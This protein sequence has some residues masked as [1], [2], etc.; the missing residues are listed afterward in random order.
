[1]ARHRAF[2]YE[3]ADPVLYE[4]LREYAKEH[5]KKPTEA[6]NILWECLKGNFW[7]T[8]FR[9]Q[10]I[11]GSYIADFA[12]LSHRLI[13]EIDGGYHQLPEQQTSDQERTEW[14]EN[15]GFTVIRF[16]NEEIIG[17]LEIVLN[18]IKA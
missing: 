3:M 4:K 1:M 16:T 18:K 10:H 8:H 12:C 11:I 6:E 2:N 5:R 14:L 15:R 13:I 17:N 9:R 7:G